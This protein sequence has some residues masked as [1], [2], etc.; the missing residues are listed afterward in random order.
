MQMQGVIVG[1]WGYVFAAWGASLAVLL[2][3]AVAVNIRLR[4]ALRKDP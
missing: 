1:G 2:I 3:Y 4:R